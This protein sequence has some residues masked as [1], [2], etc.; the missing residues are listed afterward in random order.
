MTPMQ[1]E[2]P[3]LVVYGDRFDA[4]AER[5]VRGGNLAG[6]AAIQELAEKFGLDAQALLKSAALRMSLDAMLGGTISGP[7]RGEQ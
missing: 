6:A 7:K 4:L 2:L 3:G 5:G 1:N